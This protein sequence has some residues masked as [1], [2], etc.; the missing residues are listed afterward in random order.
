MTP[1]HVCFSDLDGGAARAAYR[2]HQAQVLEGVASRMWVNRALSGDWTVRGKQSMAHT[3]A[4]QAKSALAGIARR[5]M[6]TGNKVLHSPSILPSNWPRQ[7]NQVESDVVN[8]HWLGFEMM[9]IADIGALRKPVVWTLHDMWAFCGAEHYTED[10]RWRE[11]YRAGNR[12]SHES[13]FDLN[14]WTWERKRRH[15]KRPFHIVTPSRWLADCVRESALMVNWPVTVVPNCINTSVW[16]PLGRE[17]ARDI[18]GLPKDVPLL[19]FGAAGGTEDP[20]KGFDLLKNALAHLSGEFHGLELIVFGQSAPEQPPA[21]GFPMHYMGALHDDVGLVLLYSAADAMVVPSRQEAFG[22]TASEAH[23][24][25]TPVICFDVGGL[26]DIVVHKETGYLARPF[27]TADLA[28]GIRWVLRDKDQLARL[29]LAARARA[30]AEWSQSR[31]AT[32]YDAVYRQAV[33]AQG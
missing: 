20:R 22:Q 14:R 5:A 24:C 19:L 25:G 17:L 9:S 8:L 10:S 32:E 18:L 7:L 6:R 16:R 1:S 23:A 11:G 28:T 4:S 27:D 33:Q 15:W 12:P 21:L 30:C 3:V 2:I 31:V 29:G 26:P 13:G